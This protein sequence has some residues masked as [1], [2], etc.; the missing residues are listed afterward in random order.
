MAKVKIAT[1]EAQC[2]MEKFVF[3]FLVTGIFFTE[4]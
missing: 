3:C 1:V 2:L 4:I